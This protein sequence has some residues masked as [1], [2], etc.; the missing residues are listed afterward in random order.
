MFKNIILD[1][2]DTL[3]HSVTA[4][5]NITIPPG[6]IV[7]TWNNFKTTERP[8]LDKFIPFVFSKFERVSIWTAA[9]KGYGEFIFKKILLKY[10]PPGKNF[11]YFLHETHCDDSF[12]EYGNRKYIHAL[13]R[14]DKNYT[15]GNTLMIDDNYVAYF[16][17]GLVL[18]LK[19]FNIEDMRRDDTEL[20]RLMAQLDILA[21]R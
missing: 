7:H 13:N 1:L 11:D 14:L 9:T 20:L 2:D 17:E 16:Q 19:P 21:A 8:H 4:T 12:A 18:P 6:L 10:V 3:I 15:I 5:D